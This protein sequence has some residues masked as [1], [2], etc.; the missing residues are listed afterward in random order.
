MTWR[1]AARRGSRSRPR[2]IARVIT[3]DVNATLLDLSSLDEPFERAFGDAGVRAQWFGQMLQ[4]CFVGG[5]TG[6]YVDLTSA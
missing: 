3:L 5:L 6:R 4:L 2:R 1:A